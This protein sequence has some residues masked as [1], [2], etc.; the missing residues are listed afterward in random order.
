MGSP[1][2]VR[3]VK[4]DGTP[5]DIAVV[6]GVTAGDADLW[7]GL[8]DEPVP[9]SVNVVPIMPEL[10]ENQQVQLYEMQT[11]GI[12]LSQA[13]TSP[14][15]GMHEARAYPVLA[16]Q[17]NYN[18]PPHSPFAAWFHNPYQG[19]SGTPVFLPTSEGLVL[20]GMIGSGGSAHVTL[21]SGT[22]HHPEAYSTQIT[23][24]R[25]NALI[26]ACDAAAITNGVLTTPT[27]EEVSV[28]DLD[29]PE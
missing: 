4:A 24:T 16:F 5:V 11:L 27:L 3:F 6:A 25:L 22:Y 29:F 14:V 17:F 15:D 20:Y 23:P 19:D 8:L 28:A 10:S 12:A 2:N 21:P 9:S 13:G 1:P 26:E 18:N 7:L